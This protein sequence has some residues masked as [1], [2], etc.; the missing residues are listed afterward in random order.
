MSQRWMF[1]LAAFALAAALAVSCATNPVTGRRELS[2]VSADQEQA[3]GREGFPAVVAEYGRYDDARVQ[4]YVDSVG[5]ALARVSHRPD[6]AWTF[7]V[8]DDPTVNA[9]AMPG[10]YIYITRGILAHL[11]SEAQLAG[12][13]GHEIGH[14]TAR[15]GAR[16]MTQQQV[17]GL[18]LVVGSAL[19]STVRRYGTEA[20]QALGLLMLKYSRDDETQADELGV[21]Y[22]T[23]AGWDA[24][25]IPNTYAMLKRVAERAGQRLPAFMSTH[26]DPGDRE[27]RTTALA[28][29]AVAG[30]TGLIV[31]ARDFV[32][33]TDGLP[34]GDDPRQGYVEGTRYTQPR[35]RL[36]I[37]FPAGWTV[38]DQRTAVT[39]VA[40]SKAAQM[41]MSVADAGTRGPGEFVA[42]LMQAGR[43][44]QASGRDE[45]LGGWPA[46]V[47]TVAVPDG[48]GGSRSMRVAFV[49]QA[50]DRML[51]ILGAAAATADL[52]AIGGALRTL[53]PV[54]D[55]ARLAVEPDRVRV[56]QLG[57]SGPLAQVLPRLGAQAIDAAETSVINGL[58]PDETVRAGESIKVVRPGRVK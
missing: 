40:P 16:Q 47:G 2:L 48:Q 32:R 8:L 23:R 29:Q 30:R 53:R 37:T 3:I 13:L 38:N 19:S 39:A 41:Q 52:D 14:V 54:T 56:V 58:M 46:W 21:A 15:H 5:Q 55:P 4:A 44:T 24:R 33:R 34:Y 42:A 22:A 6:L 50:S 26:P 49:R 43:V 28:A 25:E 17:L 31:R 10:G 35:M 18:G 12:V 20:Q 45:S 7:T 51:E 9:F 11:N 36:E 1:A 27:Q 57:A